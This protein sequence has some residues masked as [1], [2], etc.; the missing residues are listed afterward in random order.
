M[1]TADKLTPILGER[2]L[3]K[4]IAKFKW[5]VA[6][7]MT[8][9]RHGEKTVN[10]RTICRAYET[11]L[12][13]QKLATRCWATSTRRA[14]QHARRAGVACGKLLVT[15]QPFPIYEGQLAAKID[16]ALR[17]HDLL[18]P[19]FD[20]GLCDSVNA[21]CYQ[22]DRRNEAVGRPSLSYLIIQDHCRALQ[23]LP[24]GSR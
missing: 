7:G 17:S 10:I 9:L 5:R 12:E 20:R 8:R 4:L 19:I 14:T 24:L 15:L 11:L 13:Q 3:L 1:T 18:K 22:T 2:C 16:M 21:A 6:A 23:R